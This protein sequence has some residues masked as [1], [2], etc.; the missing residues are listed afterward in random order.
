MLN[1][2]LKTAIVLLIVSGTK[3]MNAQN[4]FNYKSDFL[5]G[6]QKELAGETLNYTT[7]GAQA[8]DAL[9][10]RSIN[11]KEYIEWE[12]QLVPATSE[13][14][15]TFIMLASLQAT[16]DSRRFDVYLNDTKYF[17]FNNPVKA[18][19]SDKSWDGLNGS[20]ME[21]KNLQFDRFDDLTGFLFFHLP[22]INFEKGKPIRVRVQGET[23]GSRSWFMV[24]K[25]TCRSNITFETESVMLNSPDD[26]KQSVR[27]NFMHITSPAKATVRFGNSD[28]EF[29]LKFGFNSFN[30]KLDRVNE[31]TK[32][33]VVTKIAGE[34]FNTSIYLKPV[35]QKT[36]YLIPHSHVDIGYTHVQDEVK[37]LQ[38]ENL[39]EGIR[40][41]EQTADYP[42][43][44]Q[45]KWNA[46]VLWAVESYLTSATPE[47]KQKFIDAVKKGWL[48]LDGLY[49]N[50]LTGLCSREEWIWNF[51]IARHISEQCGVKIE[52]A[53]ISDVP[54]WSWGIVTVLANSGIKYFSCGI[55][56]FDRIGS[57][58]KE[59]GDKPF[60]WVSPS[61]KE[62]VLT[63]V[64]EQGYAAFHSIS[65]KG[66]AAGISALEPTIVKYANKLNDESFPF[67]IIP[68][69]Y[70]V[71]G[72]NGPPDKYL[73]KN[74]K[75][76][77]EKYFSP[78]LVI[79]TTA[80]FFRMFEEK[81]GSQL[82]EYTGDITPYWEDGAGSSARETAI[83]RKSAAELSQSMAL[84][85]QFTPEES[86][87]DLFSEA[88]RNVQL[89]NE[90]TW[91]SWNS[92]SEPESDFTKQQWNIK[93][94]F[95]LDA[96]KQSKNLLNK[97]INNIAS[98]NA[99]D[100]FEVINTTSVKRTD[101]VLIPENLKSKINSGSSLINDKE[102]QV[103]LQ[104]LSDGSIVFLASEI[105]AF[106]T[107]RYFVKKSND[108][109]KF[110]SVVI[111]NKTLENE[112]IRLEIDPEKG[113]VSKMVLK[114]KGIILADNKSGSGLGEYLY[115]EG[116]RP[117]NPLSPENVSVK[118]K[119][120]GPLVSSWIV[121]A[122][123]PG[124]NSFE[125]EIRLIA[126][127][128][129]VDL[130]YTIDKKKNYTPEAIHIAFPFNIPDG[131]IHVENA[132]GYYQPGKNQ[133]KGSCNNFYTINNYV[134]I[135]NEEY[136]LTL[137][138]P[139]APLIEIGKITND[140]NH[141][142]W[143]E[144]VSDGNTIYSFL[145]NNYWHTNYCAAQEGET[146]FRYMLHPHNRFN[147]AA[148]TAH[149]L[150]VEHPLV[151][152]P[153]E[154]NT[155]SLNPFMKYD[156]ENVFVVSMQP[157]ED[158]LWVALYNASMDDTDLHLNFLS[159][160]NGIYD[161]DFMKNKL[162]EASSSISI[163]GCGVKCVII[164]Q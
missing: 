29:Q 14:T 100:A 145:M 119:E 71:G 92:I 63:W 45:F 49:S 19:L 33:P 104:Q 39:E 149:G 83:N 98:K 107:G 156:N 17:T 44:T 66:S 109:P 130:L 116:R 13:G 40:L 18:E 75:E 2:I 99:G 128:N 25:H 148:A 133:I 101:I 93:Q 110:E 50:T 141:V 129:R 96:S 126:G 84:F 112:F 41:A 56:P 6:Y 131:K 81:Y 70:N 147:P 106:G 3:S 94:A 64:H 11:S 67:D 86:P 97:A 31:E 80:E 111:N 53:M 103:P 46:E 36:I 37:Q 85:S 24:F 52:S 20:K 15:L 38:W 154:K 7:L 62:K 163:P 8:F 47:K 82:P 114:D 32:F 72:D 144:K 142:G 9:L 143:L 23:A 87:V 48:G 150:S 78:K 74:V 118:I 134:D 27:V 12:T 58:R 28:N 117:E 54:G 160:P 139:D 108:R 159:K 35:T 153:V 105:P 76:W 77:N 10:V 124:S 157:F 164:E 79:T 102:E 57:V 120:K 69:R 137:I 136:G 155:K 61:G 158:K 73:S 123:A 89:Y 68:L 4:Q 95:A 22:A 151:V 51:E 135:S 115:V 30:A 132:F 55:N 90:H 162:A 88:W 127:I 5:S 138:S 16:E 113:T 34:T 91:G 140:A 42:E 161:S 60:Y 1:R 122:D 152:I 146:T 65:K 59:L 43:G 125:Y 26:P 121:K 21:F